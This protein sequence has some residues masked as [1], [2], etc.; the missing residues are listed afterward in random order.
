MEN[1]TKALLIAAGVL[2]A[3]MVISALVLMFDRIS[4]VS[5]TEQDALVAQQLTEFNREYEAFNRRDLWGGQIISV[6]NKMLDNN[7]KYA[8]LDEDNYMMDISVK[9]TV[10][11]DFF[12]K[13]KEGTTYS[14]LVS[15]SQKFAEA[16]RTEDQLTELKRKLFKCVSVEYNEET[17]R[18]QKMYFE[19]VDPSDPNY[20]IK[21]TK[22]KKRRKVPWKMHQEHY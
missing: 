1:A 5:Q 14:T 2:I 8:T 10:I 7:N 9:F 18:V 17:G 22:K 6:M 16:Q 11:D 20:Q 15:F 12:N 13:K 19:E 3:I 21:Q 4:K